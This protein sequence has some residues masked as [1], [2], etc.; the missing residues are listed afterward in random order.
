MI[1][2]TN[3]VAVDT[4]AA[5]VMGFDPFGLTALREANRRG[6]GPVSLTEIEITGKP[7]DSV[8]RPFRRAVLSSVAV[9]DHVEVIE[10]GADPRALSALRHSQ[11]K[12]QRE[13]ILEDIKPFTIL[14][15]RFHHERVPRLPTCE[16]WLFGDDA[17]KARERI[18]LHH[19][20]HEVPGDAPHI[21]DF[22]KAFTKLH[23]RD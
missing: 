19:D 23:L 13:T 17:I 7:V 11:D 20:V 18:P 4:V 3:S 16:T 9:F 14:V 8:I 1:V 10:G 12:L 15:G 21:F 2:G 5:S 22:Y 6:F